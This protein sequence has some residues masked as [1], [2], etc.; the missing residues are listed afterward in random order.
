MNN[1]MKPLVIQGGGSLG[2][3]ER[4]VYK[5][6]AKFK[7]KC[8]IIVGTSIGGI[9]SVIISGNKM[10]Q[11]AKALEEFWLRV[12]EKVTPSNLPDQLRAWTSAFYS[13]VY[14]NPNAFLPTGLGSLA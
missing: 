1:V 4:G 12:A 6:I 8:D 14:G 9:N 13:S 2:A 5:A 11:P 10:D 3:Y 7:I